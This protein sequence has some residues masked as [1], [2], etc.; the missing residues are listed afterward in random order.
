MNARP[1]LEARVTESE[2]ARISAMARIA[3]KGWSRFAERPGGAAAE[4]TRNNALRL[5]EMMEEGSP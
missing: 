1:P 2:L 5:R 4:A 3:V